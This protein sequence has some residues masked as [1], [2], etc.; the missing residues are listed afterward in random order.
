MG[1]VDRATPARCSTNAT[2]CEAIVKRLGLLLA[3]EVVG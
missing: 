3:L 2:K 1:G